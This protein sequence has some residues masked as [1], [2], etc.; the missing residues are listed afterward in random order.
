MY[1]AS[2]STEH[3]R[4]KG[5]FFISNPFRTPVQ[6]I[7]AHRIVS[8]FIYSR[9]NSFSSD[10]SYLVSFLNTGPAVHVIF[11]AATEKKKTLC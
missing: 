7:K 1:A 10:F 8:Q 2:L 11:I 6:I 4:K 5:G 9:E 3:H